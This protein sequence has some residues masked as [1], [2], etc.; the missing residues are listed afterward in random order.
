MLNFHV[1]KGLSLKSGVKLAFLFNARACN[2]LD[3]YYHKEFNPERNPQRQAARMENLCEVNREELLLFFRQLG[4]RKR[5]VKFMA[6]EYHLYHEEHPTKRD[7]SANHAILL[8]NREKGI[9][10][11]ENGIVK[12]DF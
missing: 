2:D 1:Y 7:H 10:R 6:V 3:T 9:I 5:F 12:N 8:E 4:V 11:A